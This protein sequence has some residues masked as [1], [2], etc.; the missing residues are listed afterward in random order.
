M[1]IPRGLRVFKPE[2]R[3][4]VK[5]ASG[6]PALDHRSASARASGSFKEVL[7]TGGLAGSV[8]DSLKALAIGDAFEASDGLFVGLS[9]RALCQATNHVS[10]FDL[11]PFVKNGEVG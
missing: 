10:S 6:L 4:R 7:P 1:T 8:D 9:Q 11:A 2:G 5:A 3:R